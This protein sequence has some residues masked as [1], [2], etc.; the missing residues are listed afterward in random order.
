M[1]TSVVGSIVSGQLVSR[2]GKYKWLA[3]LGM[4]VSVAGI[5]LL[6]RLN[7]NSTNNEVLL[8]MLVLGVGWVLECHFTR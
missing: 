4:L 7:V 3:I 5:L 6:V 2:W 1:L 8:A